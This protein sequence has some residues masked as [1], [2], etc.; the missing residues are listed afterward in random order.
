LFYMPDETLDLLNELRTI[1]QEATNDLAAA[2]E[3]LAAIR[4][5]LMHPDLPA[6]ER[7]FGHRVYEVHRNGDLYLAALAKNVAVAEAAFRAL[8]EIYPDRE[9]V[10][11]WGAFTPKHYKPPD[12][13]TYDPVPPRTID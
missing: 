8:V 4:Y 12:G 1:A 9:W 7:E 3:R 11:R 10:L 2:A 5:R 13:L 6:E